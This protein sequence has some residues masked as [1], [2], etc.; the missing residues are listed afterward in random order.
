MLWTGRWYGSGGEDWFEGWSILEEES[1]NL[2]AYL[3]KGVS[4]E[5]VS[6]IIQ[7]HNNTF[8]VISSSKEKN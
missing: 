7:A 3:G 1:R 5:A 6:E 4:S 2:V 8:E